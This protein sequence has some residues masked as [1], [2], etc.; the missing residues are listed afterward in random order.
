MIKLRQYFTPGI[1]LMLIGTLGFTAMQVLIK[2]LAIFPVF[3]IVFFRSLI[4]S[5]LCM[6]YLR[7]RGIS[8]IGKNQKYLFL[9]AIFGIISMA[10]FFA[11]VQRM[12]LGASVSLKY[13]SPIF[14]AIFAVIFLNEK[15]K[16]TQ[17]LCISIALLGVFLLK[18][19]DNR[20]DGVGL[21]M[22]IIG[23]L[24]GG[25]VYV[26]IRRIGQTENPMVIVNYFMFT[27][28][29][30]SGV[31]MIPSWIHPTTT[32]W[33][34]L[35]MIGFFGYFGQIFMTKAFQ[36]EEAN[37][38]APVKYAELVY[39]MIIGYFWF[40]ESYVFMSIMGI[41]LIVLAVLSNV[42]IGLSSKKNRKL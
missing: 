21:T 37:R 19:F 6:S 2:E 22:A 33:V 23:A 38:I 14:T 17:W 12:P 9:R 27:A 28:C 25:L 32:Q 20:I 7:H 30:L 24:F 10:L 3:Q 4:T 16:N 26:V 1:R 29:V 40:G 13:L 11:T 8:L 36:I 34:L 42:I 41:L 5:L 15:M 31:A 39:S 18:G 35:I